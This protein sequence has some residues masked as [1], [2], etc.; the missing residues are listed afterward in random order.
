MKHKSY[1]R[2]W[3]VRGSHASPMKTHLGVGGNTSCVEVFANGN[4]LIFDAGTGIIPLGQKLVEDGK[5]RDL[6]IMLTHYHWDH[7][8][9]LPFFV[10]A[11]LP[12]WKINFFG[13]GR[14]RDEIKHTLKSQMQSPYF[15][16]GTESWMADISY[17][18]PD[19]LVISGSLYSISRFGVHHPG[20]TYG[21]RVRVNNK[22]IV[23]VSDN[24]CVHILSKQDHAEWDEYDKEERALLR[25]MQQ[26]EYQVELRGIRNADILIHDA[27]Y[28]PE[29]YEKKRGWGH[30]CYIDIIHM[31]IDAGV[32]Q[33]F[34]FHHDPG[35]TDKDVKNIHADCLRIIKERASTMKCSIAKEGLIVNLD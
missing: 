26:E 8:C 21:Y 16:V 4:I 15:P 19:E 18:N 14:T 7:I 34:L 2:F 33:L 24:E 30:S 5:T 25:N 31:A 3:G 17:M 23:Y 20:Q 28:T 12:D 27:Q 13:P 9:G 29:E 10:P 32:K 35:S 6:L 1:I 11:F 22:L